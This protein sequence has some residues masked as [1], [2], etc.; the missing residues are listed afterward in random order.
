M[1]PLPVPEQLKLKQAVKDS[2]TQSIKQSIFDIKANFTSKEWLGPRNKYANEPYKKIVDDISNSKPI[3]HNQLRQYIASSAILH[4]KDGWEYLSSAISALIHG[5]TS[6][7]IHFAYYAELR[8]SLSFLASD[9]IG[10]FNGYNL[11]V[12]SSNVCNFINVRSSRGLTK[13]PTHQFVWHAITE[14]SQEVTKASRVLEIIKVNGKSI[15]QWLVAAEMLSGSPLIGSLA[16]DWLKEWSL[17]L[18]ILNEDHNFRNIVSYHPQGIRQKKVYEPIIKN[19]M[20]FII[21]KWN[22]TTPSVSEKFQILDYFLLREALDRFYELKYELSGVTNRPSPKKYYTDIMLNL[23]LSP[24]TNSSLLDFLLKKS[25]KTLS[26]VFSEAKKKKYVDD[27]GIYR[28]LGII[29]RAFLLLRIST[30]AIEDILFDCNISKTDLEFWWKKIGVKHGLW[31]TGSEPTQFSDLWSDISLA[32]NDYENFQ[33]N[34]ST[35]ELK[36]LQDHQQ[37]RSDKLTQFHRAYLWGIWS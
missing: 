27:K 7:S 5:H 1:R 25:Y 2:S 24:N 35:F 20:N 9:G 4:C 32:I 31:E 19:E 30:A 34:T 21:S 33:S 14:W 28:P 22:L 8:A 16:S 13:R 26:P 29:A 15:R 3:G 6:N 23:G 37:F 11:F 10:A 18:S 17:D 12:N 36:R